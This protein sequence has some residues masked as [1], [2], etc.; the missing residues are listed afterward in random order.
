MLKE[1]NYQAAEL[2]YFSI[3]FCWIWFLWIYLHF[4]KNDDKHEQRKY[5]HMKQS[6][7]RF[8]L[9]FL[10]TAAPQNHYFWHWVIIKRFL[11]VFLELSKL[12]TFFSIE[13]I[14]LSLSKFSSC[15]VIVKIIGFSDCEGPFY[16]KPF[17][18]TL[19]MFER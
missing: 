12:K 18:S 14:V 6:F 15:S 11:N 17:L 9:L 4:K 5:G 3:V 13:S 7:C 10:S 1:K 8:S 16:R 2:A 19:Y